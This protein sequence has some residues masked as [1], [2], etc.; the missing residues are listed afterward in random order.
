MWLTNWLSWENRCV[1]P[2]T[3]FV[4]IPAHADIGADLLSISRGGCGG[5]EEEEEEEDNPNKKI[6]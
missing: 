5:R 2:M 3:G 6:I 1:P 4:A